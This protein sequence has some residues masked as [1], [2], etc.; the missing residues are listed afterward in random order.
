MFVLGYRKSLAFVRLPVLFTAALSLFAIAP[1]ALAVPSYAR[2]TGMPCGQCHTQAFGPA[3]TSFGRSFK[4][5]GYTMGTA[6][7]LPVS[8]MLVSSFTNTAQ[9][10]PDKA[11]DH[12][13]D[14]NNFALDEVGVFLA[15]KISDHMGAFIQV[16][17]DGIS[18]DTSWDNVDFRYATTLSMGAHNAV[19]G[20][21]INNSPTVQDLWSTTPVWGYPNVGSAL[22]PAPL[23]SPLIADGLGQQVLGATAYTMLDDHVYLEAGAYHGVPN[24]WLDRLAGTSQDSPRPH[25]LIPYWRAAYQQTLGAHYGSVGL[26]GLSADLQPEGSGSGS[27]QYTDY[28]W[29]A[30]YQYSDGDR[31]EID[32]YLSYIRED[33]ELK[34]SFNAG[35]VAGPSNQL[36]AIKVNLIYTLD[37]TWSATAGWFNTDGS[38]DDV[39]YAPDPVEG[40]LAGRPDSRGYLLEFE[41]IPWGKSD[42]VGKYWA[43]ARIG[44]QYTLYDRFNGGDNDYD[45][46]GRSASDNNTLFLF[47]WLSV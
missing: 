21:S 42:S 4:L 16:T 2:Q 1:T 31:H 39:L 9:R 47:V 20:V 45:G 25:N 44:V 36:N 28:G 32:A 38:R 14:N 27:N 46:F 34:Q 41:Y 35:E 15:G 10:L 24:S 13:D 18:R 17:Y 30:T 40:S 8:A 26:F 22:A 43:N 5:N 33:Q 19:V 23:G 11:A 12:F 3:L 29:D 7:A 37:K 6:R